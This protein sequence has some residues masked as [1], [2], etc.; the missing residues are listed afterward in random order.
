MEFILLAEN[1]YNV[2]KI[3]INPHIFVLFIQKFHI[4]GALVYCVFEVAQPF[5]R[6]DRMKHKKYLNKKIL[7]SVIFT[8][9]LA[10]PP[11]KY[12]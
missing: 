9:T 2:D 12:S 3:S 6:F 4:I 5:I 11:I 8:V 10:V 1:Y 7:Y